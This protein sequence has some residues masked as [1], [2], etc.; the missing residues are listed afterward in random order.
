MVDEMI[1]VAIETA[2]TQAQYAA[3]ARLFERYSRALGYDLEYQG[4]SNELTTLHEMYGPPGGTLLLA[5][6]GDDYVG[7]VGLRTFDG[8]D[9]EMKRMYVV[10]E[11]QGHGIGKALTRALLAAAHDLGYKR[12]LLDSVREL[13]TP[14]ALYRQLGFEEIGAYR[15][16]PYP[17]PVY[18]AYRLHETPPISSPRGGGD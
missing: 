12:V 13:E 14:L 8:G 2:R 1:N 6:H 11:W 9:A 4:F 16:N 5:R 7:V 3:A 10:E 15:F 17:N 18:M